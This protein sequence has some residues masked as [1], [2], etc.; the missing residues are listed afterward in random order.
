MKELFMDMESRRRFVNSM[1]AATAA[2]MGG[3]IIFGGMPVLGQQTT[4]PDG[5]PPYV[6]TGG[7]QIGPDGVNGNPPPGPI[8]AGSPQQGGAA[9]GGGAR[10]G[11]GRA[12]RP[13]RPQPAGIYW[14]SGTGIERQPGA[15][16]WDIKDH[17]KLTM[18][19]IKRGVEA[20]G[21][22]MDSFLYMQVFFCLR[23]DDSTPMPTGSAAAA[24][25]QKNYTDLT[26]IYNTYF[27]SRPPRSCFA[28]SW[29]PGSSLIEVVGAAYIDPS[30]VP[31]SPAPRG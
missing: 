11:R 17:T 26:D 12:A 10:G 14:I 21:G 28:L 7:V 1:M 30:V 18:D 8:G 4:V 29:I 22:T 31:P 3:G 19:N 5:G 27:T 9:P 13:P 25:Y 16:T 2:A 23:S 6:P 20:K 24:A 15:N